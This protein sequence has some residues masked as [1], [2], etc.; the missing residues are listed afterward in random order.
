MF[1]ILDS[2]VP[3]TPGQSTA[4]RV[5]WMH[6]LDFRLHVPWMLGQPAA[7][8]VSWTHL[9]EPGLHVPW[10]TAINCFQSELNT[11]SGRQSTAFRMSWTR[12][13][14]PRLHVHWTLGQLAAFRMSWTHVLDSWL[15]CSLNARSVSCFQS[16]LNTCSGFLTPCSLILGWS[17][18]FRMSR[19]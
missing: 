5:S 4:L 9:L 6:V 11:C 17:A 14:D 3:W 13:L 16:E 1:W 10:M 2:C 15:L 12:V 19:A 8:R 18:A 7:F